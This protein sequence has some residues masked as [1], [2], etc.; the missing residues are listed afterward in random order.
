MGSYITTVNLDELV[1]TR[2]NK[3][4]IS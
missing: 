1:T 4:S 2:L 3:K